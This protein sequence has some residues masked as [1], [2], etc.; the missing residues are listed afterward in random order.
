MNFSI[1]MVVIHS[2]KQSYFSQPNT[3]A[4]ST[5]KSSLSLLTDNELAILFFK[6]EEQAFTVIFERYYLRIVPW[7]LKVV[8]DMTVA[9]DVAQNTFI[10]A[11]QALKKGQYK[12]KGFSTWLH[13]IARNEALNYLSKAKIEMNSITLSEDHL[14]PDLPA[15]LAEEKEKMQILVHAT[16]SLTGPQKLCFYLRFNNLRYKQIELLTGINRGGAYINV[17]LATKKMNRVIETKY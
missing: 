5:R 16:D 2:V 17:G 11:V 1:N 6:G 14:S 8:K 13:V 9:E 3:Y 7:V 10:K 15:S 4:M 12:G